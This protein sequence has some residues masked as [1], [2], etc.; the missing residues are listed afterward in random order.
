MSRISPITRMVTF[1][2]GKS[3]ARTYHNV[4][5][6]SRIQASFAGLEAI[7]TAHNMRFGNLF[8]TLFTGGLTALFA[9]RAI[10][11]HNMKVDLWDKY[12]EIVE[13]AKKIYTQK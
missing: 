7:L 3:I 2:P 5:N 8:V 4:Q 1:R 11:Y 9:K 13:R 10:D 6:M 12:Q